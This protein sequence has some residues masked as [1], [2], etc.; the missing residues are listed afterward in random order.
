MFWHFDVYEPTDVSLKIR[1]GK[2]KLV[3]VSGGFELTWLKLAGFYCTRKLILLIE[4][5]HAQKKY[6]A[7][8]AY[9]VN[10]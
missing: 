4:L 10:K 1:A 5:L 8:Q 9:V 7:L 2:V 3:W 6:L